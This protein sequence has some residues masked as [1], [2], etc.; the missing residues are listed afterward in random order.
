V[1]EAFRRLPEPPRPAP[2]LA[3]RVVL[4]VLADRVAR[5]RVR[6]RVRWAVGA[7]LAAGLLL[8]LSLRFL[9]SPRP[10]AAGPEVA[11]TQAPQVS[12]PIDHP[13]PE[14]PKEEASVQV[15]KDVLGDATLTA[16]AMLDRARKETDD[17]MTIW[18]PVV[19]PTVFDGPARPV[20][21]AEGPLAEAGQGVVH[22]F[23]PV[24]GSARRAVG[25]FLRD[26]A[27]TGM[28]KQGL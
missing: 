9:P 21:P 27:P 4:A 18:R 7:A 26:L 15:T 20:D 16:R 25:L 11:Q 12:V 13:S 8:A 19:A 17:Q 14:S 23:E 24:S 28:E 1:T 3:S 2:G 22:G 10:P 6:V 5:R